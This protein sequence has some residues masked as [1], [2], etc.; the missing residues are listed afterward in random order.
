MPVFPSTDAG[1]AGPV[2][3]RMNPQS[4][5]GPRPGPVTSRVPAMSVTTAGPP[6]T[7]MPNG[8]RPA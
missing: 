7:A 1:T 6:M 3:L 4:P 8:C 5:G 2:V